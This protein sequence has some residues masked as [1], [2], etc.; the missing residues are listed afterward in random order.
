[1]DDPAGRDERRIDAD[2]GATRSR[3]RRARGRPRARR[4]SCQRRRRLSTVRPRAHSIRTGRRRCS[5]RP[6]RR[7]PSHGLPPRA[8]NPVRIERR[9]SHRPVGSSPGRSPAAP[10][11]LGRPDQPRHPPAGALPPTRRRAPDL[12]RSTSF[13]RERSGC[14]RTGT[15][16][17]LTAADRPAPRRSSCSQRSTWAALESPRARRPRP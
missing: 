9:W 15:D 6:R 7:Q 16:V 1:M 4:T 13:H 10:R 3:R 14:R 11:S 12:H 5:R 2:D 8:S 17:L